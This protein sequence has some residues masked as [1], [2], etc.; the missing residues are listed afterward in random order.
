MF[1]AETAL[2]ILSAV[3]YRSSAIV[4]IK[5]VTDAA[6]AAGAFVLWDLSHAGGSIAVELQA[7]GVDLAV[8]CTYKYLNGGPG[9]PA[10]LYVRREL[11]DELDRR[12][13]AGS[14]SASSSTWAR[15]SSASPASAAGSSGR[16]GS[17]R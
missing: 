6:R 11:Q 1:D 10:F 17:S 5:P 13:R 3:N 12:S 2:L 16:P 7:N 9:S 15:P 4:D 8:G 14:P